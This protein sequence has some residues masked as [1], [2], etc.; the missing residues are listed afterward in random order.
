MNQKL[1]FDYLSFKYK[2]IIIKAELIFVLEPA[3][4]GKWFA[5]L[6]DRNTNMIPKAHSKFRNKMKLFSLF[7]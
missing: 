1:G 4:Q 2:G 3:G 7:Y 5:L 6:V